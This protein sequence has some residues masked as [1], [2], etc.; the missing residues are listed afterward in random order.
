MK[1]LE[2]QEM[3]VLVGVFENT[4]LVPQSNIK[5]KD[6]QLDPIVSALHFPSGEGNLLC[7]GI[8]VQRITGMRYGVRR[9][10]QEGGGGELIAIH[11]NC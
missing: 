1:V 11:R 10:E 8:S 4:N 2:F 3:R 6:C 5:L 7:F 9:R